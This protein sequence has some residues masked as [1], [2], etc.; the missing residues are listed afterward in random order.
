MHQL[1]LFSLEEI[2]H[3][4]DWYFVRFDFGI[5]SRYA[6]AKENK[7][8]ITDCFLILWLLHHAHKEIQKLFSENWLVGF[9]ICK[10]ENWKVE[11]I[12]RAGNFQDN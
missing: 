5:Y 12:E 6:H 9:E 2:E 1:E 8:T 3:D 7:P 11:Y 10:L 4:G